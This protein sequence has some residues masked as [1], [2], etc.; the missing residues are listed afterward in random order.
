MN[1]ENKHKENYQR[2]FSEDGDL[3]FALQ[4]GLITHE[5]YR[6]R[7]VI[8]AAIEELFENKYGNE[9][10]RNWRKELDN[11]GLIFCSRELDYEMQYQSE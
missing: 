7:N 5:E 3:F 11:N 2:M 9:K 4:D 1:I 6:D 10:L 8:N